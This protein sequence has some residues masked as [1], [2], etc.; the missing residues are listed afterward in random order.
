MNDYVVYYLKAKVNGLTFTGVGGGLNTLAW[1]GNTP[2][3]FQVF[4]V[5]P[6]VNVLV[7]KSLI[8]VTISVF[9]RH[10][11]HVTT[12]WICPTQTISRDLFNLVPVNRS[13]PCTVLSIIPI[14]F[15]RA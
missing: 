6:D 2:S 4:L 13:A 1:T 10:M 11:F 7:I 9:L 12:A 14:P 8:Y 5:H 15:T 3:D